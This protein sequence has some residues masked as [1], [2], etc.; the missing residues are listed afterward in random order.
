MS[1]LQLNPTN[2]FPIGATFTIPR[3]TL[4]VSKETITAVVDFARKG[5]SE[6]IYTLNIDPGG[7]YP[8]WRVMTESC[9][10]ARIAEAA[11]AMM[12]V[13]A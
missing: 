13:A 11:R 5:S 9:L 7:K 8:H 4:T 6:W 3:R 1:I 12:P 2:T 10:R